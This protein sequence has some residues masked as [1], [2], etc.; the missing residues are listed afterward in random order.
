[1]NKFYLTGIRGD[2]IR[3]RVA[4]TR[5]SVPVNLTGATFRLG[6]KRWLSD[7]ERLITITTFTVDD[8]T[9]GVVLIDIPSED[10][11]NFIDTIDLNTDIQM[12]ETDG[13]KTTVAYGILTILADVV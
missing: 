4:V 12:T 9:S 5:N 3:F 8:V 11:E 13:S 1:M 7:T 10:T 6:C 2:T